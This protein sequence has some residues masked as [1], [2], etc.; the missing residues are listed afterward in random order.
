MLNTAGC[1]DIAASNLIPIV[2][3]SGLS[4]N[5]WIRYGDNV[6]TQRFSANIIK[7]ESCLNPAPKTDRA[8]TLLS[9]VTG[10]K[11]A[12]DDEVYT[13]DLPNELG[14][15]AGMDKVVVT[16]QDYPV[17]RDRFRIDNDR[18]VTAWGIGGTMHLYVLIQD[19]PVSSFH[20]DNQFNINILTNEHTPSQTKL[21]AK[22]DNDRYTVYENQDIK[23]VLINS[24]DIDLASDV[25]LSY[26]NTE[27]GK[28]YFAFT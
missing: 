15:E 7:D 16:V 4:E 27:S 22:M 21:Y 10:A 13:I 3:K 12:T 5:K 11:A 18:T 28:R 6:K 23:E 1:A 24:Q 25:A 19:T 26:L 20:Q 17:D 8:L 9:S 14:Y 2:N